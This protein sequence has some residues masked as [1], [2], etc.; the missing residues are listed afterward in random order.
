MWNIA[1]LH[2][3]RWGVTSSVQAH[4]CGRGTE[5]KGRAL[6]SAGETRLARDLGED[7]AIGTQQ[8]RGSAGRWGRRAHRGGRKDRR[9]DLER[10]NGRH[11][12]CL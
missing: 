2:A 3:I 11:D 5:T 6:G 9:R 10:W 7:L 8:R 1:K 4:S 12:A